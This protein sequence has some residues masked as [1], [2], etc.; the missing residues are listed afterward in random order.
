MFERAAVTT[1][2]RFSVLGP[3]RAWRAGGEIDL[4]SPQQRAVLAILLLGDGA[5]IS[6]DELVTALWGA[7]PPRTAVGTIRTYVSR[8][9]RLLPDDGPTIA[10]RAGGYVLRVPAEALD[11]NV[12]HQ[13][14]ARARSARRHGDLMTA[15]DELR[16]GLAL[17]RG[18]PLAGVPGAFAA[19]HRDH[20]AGQRIAALR[21]LIATDLALGRHAQLVLELSQADS[22]VAA[23]QS[24]PA[25][26]PP[27]TPDFVGRDVELA[28]IAEL[29]GRSGGVPVVAVTGMGGAGKSALA[30]RAAH[31]LTAAFPDGQ[32]YASLGATTD[33]PADPFEVLGGFLRAFGVAGQELPEQ[34]A[35]RAALW[36][37]VTAGRRILL[38]LD[39]I[40]DSHQVRDLLPAT[41]G[42]AVLVTSRRRILDLPGSRW[43]KLGPLSAGEALILLERIVGADRVHRERQAAR[44]LV[45]TCSHLPHAVRL[46]GHRL[47]ARRPWTFAD[48]EQDVEAYSKP[49]ELS[50]RRLEPE[51]ARAFRMLASAAGP[52][53][54][55]AEAAATLGLAEAEVEEICEALADVHLIEPGARGRYHWVEL[56]RS[57]ARRRDPAGVQTSVSL[58]PERDS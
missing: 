10:S 27:G 15:S 57:F 47:K 24:V 25:Q 35:E 26:L 46:A 29:L 36:R 31:Q 52:G 14:V 44:R 21:E 55:T 42:C 18:T 45:A 8:L 41:P 38:V 32:V 6:R 33:R 7:E 3:V 28:E 34:A 4:G 51:Q 11:L 30:V 5:P 9:R 50:Y 1:E 58:R 23:R 19:T 53:I 37:T 39:D 54:S 13:H 43:V 20:L 17:W 22:P 2:V 49:F 56:V 12:F 16:D 40:V 48:A